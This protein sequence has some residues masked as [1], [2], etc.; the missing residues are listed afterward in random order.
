MTRDHSLH[1][2]Y[3]AAMSVLSGLCIAVALTLTTPAYGQD[4]DKPA[5]EAKPTAVTHPQDPMIWDVDT[6]MEQAVQQISKRYSLNPQQEQYT[7]LLL[8]RRVREFLDEHET[9][10]RELLQESINMRLGKAKSDKVALQIWAQRAMPLYEEASRAILDGNEEWGVI[11]TPEQKEI[12]DKDL[13]LMEKSFAGATNTMKLWSE[14]KGPALTAPRNTNSNG[15]TPTEAGGVAPNPPR[16][17]ILNIEDNW[18]SYV[19]MFVSAYELDQSAQNSAKDKI[20]KEQ[21]AKAQKYR[22][23]RAPDFERIAARIKTLGATEHSERQKLLKR[24]QLLERPI[25][26]LFVEMDGRLHKLPTAAQAANVS[27][28]KKQQLE[29]LYAALAGEKGKNK[30]G[31]TNDRKTTKQSTPETTTKPEPAVEPKD[32]PAETTPAVTDKPTPTDDAS[33]A[34][35]PKPVKADEKPAEPAKET[36]KPEASKPDE[37]VAA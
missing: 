14:G 9:E 28:D 35:A 7:R 27:A 4:N 1:T 25:Y 11:L 32:K 26:D 24:Q 12:H 16:M 21:Y 36:D 3:G 20:L 22:D 31:A 23:S 15:E 13:N 17:P 29:T 33:K 6:M 18:K 10:V 8:T 2:R 30:R 19:N 37:R 34:D 5:D